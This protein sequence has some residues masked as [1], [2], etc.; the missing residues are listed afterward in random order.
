MELD[1][2]PKVPTVP[3]S[4]NH[5]FSGTGMLAPITIRWFCS[6]WGF[7]A[8]ESLTVCVFASSFF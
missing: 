6:I 5:P 4:H 7:P 2:T 3:P 1:P 8:T